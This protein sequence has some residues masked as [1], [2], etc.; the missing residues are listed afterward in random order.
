M[1]VLH[2]GC[3]SQST[4]RPW[5]WPA[6]SNPGGLSSWIRM[7]R[8]VSK[9]WTVQIQTL[10]LPLRQCCCGQSLRLSVL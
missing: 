4:G 7:T 9:H 3:G 8:M 6:P 2:A 10:V 1:K 5:G